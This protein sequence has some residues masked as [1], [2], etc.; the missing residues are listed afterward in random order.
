[1]DTRL[2]KAEYRKAEKQSDNI[3]DP[4]N[5][6]QEEPGMSFYEWMIHPLPWDK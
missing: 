3:I 4:E 1:M 6:N 2:I 5:Q